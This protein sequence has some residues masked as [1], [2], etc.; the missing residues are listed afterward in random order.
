M[1]RQQKFSMNIGTN[2]KSS[3]LWL[4]IS[5]IQI[6]VRYGF[7]WWPKHPYNIYYSFIVTI[8]YGKLLQSYFHTHHHTMYFDSLGSSLIG[9]LLPLTAPGSVATTDHQNCD[10]I[11]SNEF[12][13]VASVFA[14]WL[15]VNIFNSLSISI[16]K[17]Q[18][19]IKMCKRETSIETYTY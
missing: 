2:T 13:E 19:P 12:F 18:K 11:S 17:R 14:I 10:L 7:Q 3:W 1:R 6:S 16:K 9:L 5:S 8:M 4:E 15:D